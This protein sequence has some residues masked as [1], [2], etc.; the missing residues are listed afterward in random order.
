M[1]VDREFKGSIPALY[2]RY[3]GPMIFAPY[4][5]DIASRL[6]NIRHGRILETAA[7][8]GVVTRALV[9]ALPESV[10]I[11]ATDLNQPM[12]DL[13]SSQLSSARV[14]WRQADAQHLPYPDGV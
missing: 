2:D 1:E 8:T 13:A 12:L 7:G 11:E 9:T 14:T 4:A 3:M 5:N 6:R 10:S